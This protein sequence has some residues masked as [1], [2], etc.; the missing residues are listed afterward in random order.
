VEMSKN[1]SNF[2]EDPKNYSL[3][4]LAETPSLNSPP[5]SPKPFFSPII[6]LKLLLSTGVLR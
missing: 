5:P 2:L 6:S 3:Y 4:E 1:F